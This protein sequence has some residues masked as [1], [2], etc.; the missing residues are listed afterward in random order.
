MQDRGA[1]HIPPPAQVGEPIPVRPAARRATPNAEPTRRRIGRR[2]AFLGLVNF[3][4]VG[5]V[6]SAIWKRDTIF[7]STEI[8]AATPQP[9]PTESAKPERPAAAKPVESPIASAVKPESKPV[10]PE[11]PKSVVDNAVR[12]V[13]TIL[14]PKFHGV[15]GNPE[16]S[17]IAESLK[18]N[19]ERV[20]IRNE[21]IVAELGKLPDNQKPERE[22][23][24]RAQQADLQARPRFRTD[25]QK[26]VPFFGEVTVPA[27][28]E[29]DYKSANALDDPTRVEFF[30][31]LPLR[32]ITEAGTVTPK[33]FEGRTVDTIKLD[34]FGATFLTIIDL[35][36]VK[37]GKINQYIDAGNRWRGEGTMVNGSKLRMVGSDDGRFGV[38]ITDQDYT[39]RPSDEP[40][41][42][43]PDFPKNVVD[44]PAAAPSPS[45]RAV[46]SPLPVGR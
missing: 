1:D 11:A 10:V 36:N 33:L 3:G 37:G 31:Q 25:L 12:T 44:K 4:V 28:V 26:V 7:G 38:R 21:S 13:R 14:K 6:G 24:L 18:T 34:K 5:I 19:T 2:A 35:K 30:G 17:V 39:P 41:I 23:K 42:G 27:R 15:L 8:V 9:K 40:K 16:G 20:A 43:V 32:S 29:A 46:A 45:P 22:K